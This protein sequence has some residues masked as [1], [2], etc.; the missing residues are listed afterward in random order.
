LKRRQ[1]QPVITTVSFCVIDNSFQATYGVRL[2][3]AAMA[4]VKHNFTTTFLADRLISFSLRA[5]YGDA[6]TKVP[7]TRKTNQVRRRDAPSDARPAAAKR[8]KSE[9]ESL[10]EKSPEKKG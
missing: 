5:E 8:K 7:K 9:A 1:L 2:S 6:R 4:H 10:A 3:Y